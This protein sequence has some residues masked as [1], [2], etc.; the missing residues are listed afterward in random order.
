DAP[1]AE[2]GSKAAAGRTNGRL[3]NGD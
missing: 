3:T 2:T 1:P